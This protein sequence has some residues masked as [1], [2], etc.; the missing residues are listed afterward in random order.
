[1]TL[2]HRL[3]IAA[4]IFPVHSIAAD[5]PKLDQTAINDLIAQGATQAVF[6]L[7]FERGDEVFGHTYSGADGV[8]VAIGNGQRFTRVPRTDLKGPQDWAAQQ[9][10]RFT[11][12]N[13]AGCEICHNQP[14]G[15]GAGA[16]AMNTIRDPQLLGDLRGFINRNPPHIFGI[17]A[18]QLL[19]EEITTTLHNL[20]DTARTDAERT[21]QS[22]S[23]ALAA[24][25]T[26]YGTL[27][28]HPDGSLDLSAVSGIDDDLILRPLEWKGLTHSVR[29]FVRNAAHQELGMQP[30]E[31]VGTDIDADFDGVTN[32][33]SVGEITALVIYQ[34][35]QPRPV[36]SIELNALGLIDPLSPDEIA[37]IEYGEVVFSDLG[38]AA[39]HTPKMTL[40]NSVFQEPSRHPLYRDTHFPSGEAAS[41]H[42]L[43]QTLPVRFDLAADL[44]DNILHKTDGATHAFGNFQKDENGRTIVA[45]YS[46]LKRHNMGPELAEPVAEGGVAANMFL[47]QELW[48]VAST[49]PYLHDGRATTLPDAIAAHG[50]EAANAR[51]DFAKAS[52][53]DRA[54]LIA[55]LDNLVLF[56]LPEED[57]H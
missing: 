21:G 4:V 47:T 52:D 18:L 36:T 53:A 40:S 46:D 34:A 54:A 12:P 3:L 22:Q 14:F 56:K 19:A 44:P 16:A 29:A 1:M 10:T 24:K 51:D 32:E 20:R 25:G 5:A 55:F 23:V 38:C 15:D 41:D 11:G 35:A 28:A 6:D 31:L 27:I 39:C 9:P 45:L 2:R 43:S 8:G 37:Q 50:G 42:Q 33:L 57:G 49:A 17:G 26:N 7:T 30:V 48:G 13:A